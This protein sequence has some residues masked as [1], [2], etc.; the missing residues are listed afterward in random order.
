M[1]PFFSSALSR[2][3]SVSSTPSIKVFSDRIGHWRFHG[4]RIE[5]T[6]K[7]VGNVEHVAGEAGNSVDLGIGNLTPGALTKI[8]HLGQR[9]QRL[10]ACLGQ[11]P[12]ERLH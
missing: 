6:L 9:A 1:T 11:L 3:R 8:F 4:D 2:E 10:V 12:G 5:R 7:A